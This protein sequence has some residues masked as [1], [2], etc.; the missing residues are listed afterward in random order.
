MAQ[1]TIQFGAR[2]KKIAT[3]LWQDLANGKI[4]PS[5]YIGYRKL[6]NE[7]GLILV[8][9]TDDGAYNDYLSVADLNTLTREYAIS[10]DR[11]VKLFEG[12]EE[13]TLNQLMERFPE[14]GE[15]GSEMDLNKSEKRLAR[16]RGTFEYPLGEVPEAVHEEVTGDVA[17]EQVKQEYLDAETKLALEL[18]EQDGL[19]PDEAAE[20]AEMA[21][22]G[23]LAVVEI[24]GNLRYF[25]EHDI[26][27]LLEQ[28]GT[29]PEA[30]VKLMNP[31][32]YQGDNDEVRLSDLPEVFE[33]KRKGGRWSEPSEEAEKRP[34]DEVP[35]EKPLQKE[36]QIAP[37]VAAG[38]E[39]SRLQKL[40]E[41]LR[42]QPADRGQQELE[43]EMKYQP[44]KEDLPK[45]VPTGPVAGPPQEQP[46]Q[47]IP[48]EMIGGET[49]DSAPIDLLQ[50]SKAPQPLM[51]HAPGTAKPEAAP[52]EQPIEELKKQQAERT[53]AL[54][55]AVAEQEAAQNRVTEAELTATGGP[56]RRIG[57]GIVGG[58]GIFGG[59][60]VM[61]GLI[62]GGRW[63][64]FF[65]NRTQDLEDV[66]EEG[67]E[68]VT[69]LISMIA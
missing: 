43:V 33:Q 20:Y 24:N 13:I 34:E 40:A 39:D 51:T 12:N 23:Q 2:E 47:D 10:G 58:A 69:F 68:A 57:G 27:L 16:L 3:L 53:A 48:A 56:T 37:P 63:F 50:G 17:E 25:S 64:S 19:P 35:A 52:E 46:L 42:A 11:H 26:E 15:G 21:R 44:K 1:N 31:N 8:D 65:R 60:G 45:P 59:A 14:R 49:G 5:A 18:I 32:W 55:E 67:V 62:E 66:I 54:E 9:L 4:D 7:G 30:T 6:L 22:L 61:F 41:E 36:P 28:E 38:T 29:D